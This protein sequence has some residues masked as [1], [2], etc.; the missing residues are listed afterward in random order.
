MMPLRPSPRPCVE[1]V[2]DICGSA[3][4]GPA[5]M[6]HSSMADDGFLQRRFGHGYGAKL[7]DA[8]TR[9]VCGILGESE[10]YRQNPAHH[11][12]AG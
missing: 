12:P 10:G 3:A 6:A 4:F 11:E 2:A 1:Q 5:Y 8:P 9:L 7:V